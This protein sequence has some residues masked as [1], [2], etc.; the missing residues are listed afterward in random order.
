MTHG[1]PS[2][3]VLVVLVPGLG[4]D[5]RAWAEVSPGLLDQGLVVLLPSLGQPAGRGTDLTVERQAGRLLRAVPDRRRLILVGHSAREG[6]WFA[7]IA[8]LSSNVRIGRLRA[9]DIVAWQAG[10]MATPTDEPAL[11]ADEVDTTTLDA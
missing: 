2:E 4:L 8:D 1:P 11:G 9:L 10:H 5:A 7:Q 6:A 3:S